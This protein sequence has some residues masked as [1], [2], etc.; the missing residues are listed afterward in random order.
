MLLIPQWSI[1]LGLLSQILQKEEAAVQQWFQDGCI[2]EHMQVNVRSLSINI[3]LT[4]DPESMKNISAI[5]YV[6]CLWV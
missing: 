6:V 1:L 5:A 3:V 2:I 4:L